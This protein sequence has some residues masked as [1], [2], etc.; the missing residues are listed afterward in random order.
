MVYKKGKK[1]NIT[2]F[3]VALAW[4]LGIT[5]VGIL[6]SGSAVFSWLLGIMIFY[7]EITKKA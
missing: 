3:A 5:L 4:G 7:F 2:K 1:M 6:L